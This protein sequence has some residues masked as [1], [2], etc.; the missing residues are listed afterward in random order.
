MTEQQAPGG[1]HEAAAP[2]GGQEAAAPRGANHAAAPLRAPAGTK[3][4]LW[5]ESA[6]WMELVARFATRATRAGFGLAL[7]PLFEEARLFHRGIGDESEV[8]NKEMY[9]FTDRGGRE[10][11]LRPEGTAPVVRAF[12]QHHPPVPWKAWYV[13]PAF[14]YERP[15]AG[16][17]RQHHQVG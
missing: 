16:R 6:R 17:Y 7:T 8:V 13:T 15:Q 4:V 12:V 10:M 1:A 5:P 3:D 2:R 9:E 14:R 11:A